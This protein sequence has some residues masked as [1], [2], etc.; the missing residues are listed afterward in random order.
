MSDKRVSIGI[1]GSVRLDTSDLDRAKQKISEL[2]TIGS[3]AP[4]DDGDADSGDLLRSADDLNSVIDHVFEAF[5]D[6]LRSAAQSATENIRSLLAA[7]QQALAEGKAATAATY[8]ERARDAA[9]TFADSYRGEAP[10]V[11]PDTLTYLATRAPLP[12]APTTPPPRPRDPLPPT[13][14]GT[15]G[16][17]ESEHP[18]PKTRRRPAA[19]ADYARSN[20]ERGKLGLEQGMARASS[21][22]DYDKLLNRAAGAAVYAD[23]SGDDELIE[24]IKSLTE[25]LREQRRDAEKREKADPFRG[26]REAGEGEGKDVLA[27]GLGGLLGGGKLAGA[28]SSTLMGVLT[29]PAFIAVAVGAA[30]VKAFNSASDKVERANKPARDEI[31]GLADL[32]RQMGV[33]SNLL[34]GDPQQPGTG[35]RPD[36]RTNDRFFELGYS[37]TDAARVAANYDAPSAVETAADRRNPEALRTRRLFDDTENI[38]EFSRA[39]GIDEGDAARSA[40]TLTYAGAGGPE[41]SLDIL[42]RAMASAINE[43]LSGSTTMQSLVGFAQQNAA[44]G[45][46]TSAEA[47][48][49]YAANT[50]ALNKLGITS[51]RGEMGARAVSSAVQGMAN[52]QDEGFKAL[53]VQA[54]M[55][56]YDAGDLKDDELGL[57]GRQI[58]GFKAAYAENPAYAA[59]QALKNV[60]NAPALQRVLAESYDKSFEGD[61]VMQGLAL[62]QLGQSAA[63]SFAF[64]APGASFTELVGNDPTA[65]RTGEVSDP[66]AGNEM[67]NQTLRLGTMGDDNAMMRSIS[68]LTASSNFEE[69][70]RDIQSAATDFGNAVARFVGDPS[71]IE[72]GNMRGTG[73]IRDA[74]DPNVGLDRLNEGPKDTPAYR[75]AVKKRE[76]TALEASGE[77]I[78]VEQRDHRLDGAPPHPINDEF[79]AS[80]RT[81]ESSGDYGATNTDAGLMVGAY[82]IAATNFD[83]AY[84]SPETL[85]KYGSGWDEQYLGREMT[86]DELLN[87]PKAQDTIAKGVMQDWYDRLP[88]DLSVEERQRR[89]TAMWYEGESK[90]AAERPSSDLSTTPEGNYP[91]QKRYNDEVMSR[92]TPTLAPTPAP[93]PTAPAEKPATAQGAASWQDELE[94]MLSKAAADGLSQDERNEVFEFAKQHYIERSWMEP[95]QAECVAESYLTDRGFKT[96]GYTGDGEADEVAGVVHKDEFVVPSSHM[97]RFESLLLGAQQGG[98]LD[99][100]VKLDLSGN[101]SITSNLDPQ[102]QAQLDALTRDYS[103]R[104]GQIVGKAAPM[105]DPSKGSPANWTG[106]R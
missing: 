3:G 105:R 47:L 35:F 64:M 33:S 46:A 26:I 16:P 87:D 83:N 102:A 11:T 23:R 91:S 82:Q 18:R 43:G 42:R 77:G 101:A 81:Q 31:V 54:F 106:P 17:D 104:V 58:E 99:V 25:S 62:E 51:L 19:Y 27:Q 68:A 74:I 45:Q 56:A 96:G 59:D 2:N 21:V 20:A 5:S 28:L 50:D 55:Q 29:N 48:A 30:S 85:K 52:P 22:G 92:V 10:K 94:T 34:T 90:G 71:K 79:L 40:N 36:G 32:G 57:Q 72:Q 97:D 75:E 37:A 89:V 44:Q 1:E 70:A 88:D 49:A 93:K 60:G 15:P 86:S 63:N 100:N 98:S 7:E 39:T 53:N 24:A 84:R 8:A 66:Q 38:L 73:N 9:A 103:A 6:T 76:R 4:R 61:P 78:S 80:V 69:A 12:P 14:V 65:M 95:K 13:P 41:L 67:A